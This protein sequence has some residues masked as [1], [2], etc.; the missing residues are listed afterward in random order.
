FVGSDAVFAGHY[1]SLEWR[2]VPGGG[3]FI[4]T[5]VRNFDAPILHW[6][7]FDHSVSK[8]LNDAAFDLTLMADWIHDHSGI[9]R[10][11]QLTQFHFA[12]FRIDGDLGDLGGK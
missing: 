12:G 6:Q 7:I 5:E 3:N 1:H 10:C 11:G 9:V 8:S 4:L 2:N